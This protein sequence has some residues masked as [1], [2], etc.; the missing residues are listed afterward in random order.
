MSSPILTSPISTMNSSA[1]GLT[2]KER[3]LNALPSSP[4]L[5]SAGNN[6]LKSDV[7][8]SEDSLASRSIVTPHS[9][10]PPSGD[11]IAA[12]H[13]MV[14]ALHDLN[15]PMSNQ[16]LHETN[17]SDTMHY[18]L[19]QALHAEEGSG[20]GN[21]DTGYS[22]NPHGSYRREQK[23]L[24]ARLTGKTNKQKERTHKELRKN[25]VHRTG[26]E[27]SVNNE[28][29]NLKEKED[30]ANKKK[31]WFGS[32]TAGK[33]KNELK[34]GEMIKKQSFLN[35]D[36]SNPLGGRLMPELP[37]SM[38]HLEDHEH[39]HPYGNMG[40]AG[41]EPINFDKF[42]KAIPRA[43][44]SAGSMRDNKHGSQR[45]LSDNK[46]DDIT[47]GMTSSTR[48]MS[49]LLNSNDNTN[50]NEEPSPP[51]HKT[52]LKPID[53]NH[54]HYTASRNPEDDFAHVSGHQWRSFFG[55]TMAT[56]FA[57][58]RL[59]GMLGMPTSPWARKQ[60][61]ITTLGT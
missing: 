39:S 8:L 34:P 22:L 31:S 20:D 50:T 19:T 21:I 56:P 54:G 48:S 55:G 61:N 26:T 12:V 27:R 29:A 15:P 36:P 18:P 45:S 33:K 14:K 37:S 4:Q 51:S 52:A 9:G 44:K 30:E 59:S 24:I 10:I 42:G 1:V 17:F 43:L 49:S 13:G 5:L 28:F 53:G 3:A 23:S 6:I 25:P 41:E 16:A 2:P 57:S 46:K 7:S 47:G 32:F 40:E 58:G 38:K 60:E 11:H 35:I